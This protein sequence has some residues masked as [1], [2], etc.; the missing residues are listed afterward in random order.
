M[1][2]AKK[3]HNTDQ[4]EQTPSRRSFLNKLWIGLGIVAVVEFVG[5]AAAFLM[6]R[7]T[8]AKAGDFGTVI[9]VG[10]ADK[11]PLDSVTAF[12]RGKFYLARLEDGG[13]LALARK[14]THLGCTVPWVSKEKK[15]MC[16]C[17]ASQFDI[18]GEVLSPPAPRALD[19]YHV[20]VENDIIK[21]DTGKR[22]KRSEF[23]AEHVVY[24]KKNLDRITG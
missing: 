20:F 5:V 10:P 22:I 2:K 23:R 7:R 16:P 18:R 19:I 3:Q 24:T 13:F 11:F 12:I 4:P 1:K 8:K 9:D 15:F 6:P 17:H 14:C 21:V